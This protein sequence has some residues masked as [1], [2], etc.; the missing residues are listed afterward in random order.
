MINYYTFPKLI[1]YLSLI[2]FCQNIHSQSIT[3]I[4]LSNQNIDENTTG[5]IADISS[6]SEN[7]NLTFVSQLVA[8]DGDTN[9]ESFQIIN[10]NQLTVTAPFNFES[11]S[12]AS[13][14]IK[15]SLSTVA[16]EYDLILKGIIDFNTPLGGNS[17]KA[18]HLTAVR[19]IA[20]L[21]IYG[22]GV[23]NNGSGTD[24][25]EYIFPQI[26]ANAGDQIL[27]ARY[28]NEFSQYVDTSQY[29]DISLDSSTTGAISMNGNDAIELF[30]NVGT[31]ENGNVLFEGDVIEIFGDVN[32]NPDTDGAG[33]GNDPDCWD[34][35]DAWAYKNNMGE[36]IFGEV[37]CTDGYS[38]HLEVPE[39]CIYPFVNGDSGVTYFIS[40]TDFFEKSFDITVN[41]I[42]DA[43][44]PDFISVEAIE[45]TP[46]NITLSAVDPDSDEIVSFSVQDLPLNGVLTDPENNNSS[47]TQGSVL[48]G[49]TITYTSNSDSASE[50]TFTFLV[51]DG[52]L[53][54]EIS[55]LVDILITPVDDDAYVHLSSSDVAENLAG[56]IGEFSVY[57]P[58]SVNPPYTESF[59]QEILSF[60]YYGN[61]I[62]GYTQT[63]P[64]TGDYILQI[65]EDYGDGLN[66]GL[67][68]IF[69]DGELIIE[70][71]TI[72][73]PANFDDADCWPNCDNPTAA[74]YSFSASEGQT[75][76]FE[77]IQ[78]PQYSD[79]AIITVSIPLNNAPI[80]SLDVFETWQEPYS[81]TL[82]YSGAYQLLI[83]EDYGDGLNGT[84]FNIFLDGELI[85]EGATIVNGPLEQGG[86]DCWNNYGG[87]DTDTEIGGCIVQSNAIY[88]F[89]AISGQT[90]SYEITNFSG[91]DDNAYFHLSYMP[92]IIFNEYELVSG[93]G[94][95]DNNKFQVIENQLFLENSV[96]FEEQNE[97][98]I[99]IKATIDSVDE[100]ESIILINVINVNDIYINSTMPIS[101]CAGDGTISID[102]IY[103]TLGEVTYNWSGPNGF[104]S[105]D[106]SIEN[107]QPGQY[108]FTVTDDYFSYEEEFNLEV[109]EIYNNLEICYVTSD[110]E[111]YTKNRIF[112]NTQ[113]NYNIQDYLIYA[114]TTAVDQYELIGSISDGESSFLD[115]NTNNQQ[116]QKKYKVATLDS[117]GNISDLS[118]AHYNT[119]LSATVAVDG[120]VSLEWQ[121]YVGVAY[122]T[123]N[124]WRRVNEGEFNLLSQL[125]S[126]QFNYNDTEADIDNFNYEYY[127]GIE[128][129]DCE[130]SKSISQI[131]E[132]RSNLLNLGLLSN[133]EFDISEKVTI[134]PNPAEDYINVKL[135]V[136]LELIAI[137]IFNSLGQ[138]IMTT[139]DLIILNKDL[140][141]GIYFFKVETNNGISFKNVIVK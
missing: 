6:V 24:G 100:V 74:F 29:W 20:D 115:V 50:D 116:Q 96:N 77:S 13:L 51:S 109:E 133:N 72:E 112:L 139:K 107:L 57:D 67:I 82:E 16:G 81:E 56:I 19:D 18:I 55:G 122:S 104:S 125:P 102:N 44:V 138:K 128:V 42:N 85:I 14:R 91:Y 87:P 7:E 10:D 38:T 84:T 119:L 97:L 37:N 2:I 76:T 88:N 140:Q 93:D 35:E 136:G 48:S 134:Y 120:S 1:T 63:I 83:T 15:S 47:L 127:V 117:C 70:N 26:P 3:D 33:C 65:T 5:F 123:F 135:D 141:S 11:S 132:L 8:G 108:T 124:I 126:N 23:A 31:D 41:D 105:S 54:S 130:S 101:Y 9:N 86:N 21:S 129:E 79:N 22:I 94:D 69:L 34:Y 43:P 32:V 78:Q 40:E 12:S 99:R 4:Q 90:I 66:G 75:L 92:E 46:V 111:D 89:N 98:S 28:L 80:F 27:V 68:N 45:Q 73:E 60:P 137:E 52:I 30:I 25:V 131:V 58:D 106:L 61:E 103:E 62:S 71:A 53:N 64:Y 95:I 113:G 36:W 121:P 118:S 59:S 17:G 39:D 49:N 114:E 110:S